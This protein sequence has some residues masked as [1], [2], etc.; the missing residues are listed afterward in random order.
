[1][2]REYESDRI[3][4]P[5]LVR[6]PGGPFLMGT[7]E[8]EIERLARQDDLAWKWKEKGYFRREQPQHTVNLADYAM[9]RYPVTVG[10]Y[11]PFVTAGGY[12]Q[13]RHWT[14]AGW[15]WRESVARVQPA[16]WDDERWTGNDRLPVVGV[17]W[18]EAIA[19][20]RWLS[21]TTGRRYRLPTEAEWEKAA[22]GSDGRLYPWGNEFDARFCNTSAGGLGRTLPVDQCSP[23]GQ[24]AHGCAGMAGNTSAAGL[25]DAYDVFCV[26]SEGYRERFIRK[27]V[28]PEKIRVTG[29][30]NFDNLV[31]A[32][33]NDF[34]HRGYVLVATSD[35]RE[36][37]RHE[38]RMRFLQR[39]LVI[40]DG[41]PLVFKLHPNEKVERA[42][43]E[44][45][46]VAPNAL[47]FNDG[48]TNHMIANC[49]ALIT[50][51]S[52]VVYVGLALGK[53]VHSYFDVDELRKLA[54]IQNGGTSGK[55]IA[56]I[57][58]QLLESPPRESPGKKTKSP[59]D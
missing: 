22:R 48:N 7:S 54:P 5:D 3:T 12:Q 11:R 28:R 24:S 31:Q 20:C 1:M 21:E 19:Y 18:Y 41:R 6:I 52:T 33:D 17:S 35:I 8:A 44:I 47:I 45:R 36:T 27:G 14:Q 23:E 39:C 9:A 56:H 16:F 43:R 13:R 10:A 32:Q 53:E 30:P 15:A 49:D 38:N 2:S 46:R 57:C 25:S 50:Q 51:Y 55:N 34:P 40:A 37:K 29:I 26:A 58:R 59:N 4:E 42:Y